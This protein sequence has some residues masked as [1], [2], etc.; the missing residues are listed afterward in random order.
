MIHLM[1]RLRLLGV[2][3]V[4]VLVAAGRA[5][6][7]LPAAPEAKAAP[8]EDTYFG[9]KVTDPYRWM[10]DPKNPDVQAY[11]K[12]QSDRT[13]AILDSIPGRRA[14]EGR[15][16]ALVETITSSTD[17]NRRRSPSSTRSCSRAPAS[18]GSTF[19][20]GSTEPSGSSSTRPRCRTTATTRPSRTTCPR[21]TAQPWPSGFRRG[22]RRT[23]S[24][25]SWTRRAARS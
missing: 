3:S 23:P 9:T 1:H 4:G 25:T 22:A 2:L 7:A 10:E 16:E 20:T 17:V 24:C 15:I 12:A 21:M 19:G 14:M 5:L 13:R 18:R 11:L 6:A 8:V